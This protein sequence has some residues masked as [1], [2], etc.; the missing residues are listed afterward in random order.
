VAASIPHVFWV[1]LR[2]RRQRSTRLD[3]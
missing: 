3:P 2:D 1:N